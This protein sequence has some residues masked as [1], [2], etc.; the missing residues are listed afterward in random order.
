MAPQNIYATSDA[1]LEVI[2]IYDGVSPPVG[3]TGINDVT[4]I[5]KLTADDSSVFLTGDINKKMSTF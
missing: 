5:L 4:Y 3:I 1:S 2:A